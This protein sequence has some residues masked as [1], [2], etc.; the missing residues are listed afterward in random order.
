M[1]HSA[2]SSAKISAL[3]PGLPPHELQVARGGKVF[4]DGVV[5]PLDEHA[6]HV[7]PLEQIGH[8]GTVAERVYGPPA[9]RSDS[10]ERRRVVQVR[11]RVK[12]L[13]PLESHSLQQGAVKGA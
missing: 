8:G 1:T 4:F 6:G 10:Y 5:D 3:T 9:A 11:A 13:Q 12:R 2:V 7:G